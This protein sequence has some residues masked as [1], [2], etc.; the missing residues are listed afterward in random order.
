MRRRFAAVLAVLLL[1]G[2]L[3][4]PARAQTGE[5]LP[6][7]V[8]HIVQRGETL[9]SI[10]RRYGVTVDA[11]THA[12]GVS[13]PRRIYVGQRLVIPRGDPIAGE[14]ETIAYV[15][16][17]GD[18]LA[19][20]AR[21]YNTTWQ[22]LVEIND[23]LSPNV[24]YVGQVIQVPSSDVSV[25]E[26]AMQSSGGVSYVVRP[27]DTLVGIALRHG[28]SM[29]LLAAS[30]HVANP[31]LIYP[32]QELVIPGEGPGLLPDPFAYVE[33]MPLPVTQG[34]A[35]V[36]AVHAIGPVTL[37]GRMFEREV[38]FAEEGG[39]HYAV[40]GVDAL[41]E[42]GLYELGLIATD[43]EGHNA[44]ITTGV[45]VEEGAF[46]YERISVRGSRT[47]LLDPAVVAAERERLRS[48]VQTFSAERLW[49]GPFQRPGAGTISSFFG[50]H[51][52]YNGG[53]YTAYH[54]GVDLRA[55]TG[56]P[57]YACA[58]GTVVMAELTAIYG[59]LIV[60]DHGWGVLSGYG[61]LSTMEVAAGQQVAAGDLIGKVGNTGLS[62]GSHLHWEVWVGGISVNSLQ[63]LDESYPWSELEG[64]AA[65]G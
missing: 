13:D 46:G 3:A 36:V 22:T 54:S 39:V 28:V 18:T 40:V 21:R 35:V 63:W 31:A 14:R 5:P 60:V 43:A 32:G 55:P 29:W 53:P 45:V 24:A 10:T 4:L 17:A 25:E 59:N 49:T 47:S 38:H 6:E 57:V 12:N 2:G 27:G 42:P 61:H 48:S 16:Q 33:L 64:L 34:G 52:S 9:L 51:R 65:G 1:A 44:M 19:A 15:V 8:V 37:E 26:G 41:R 7:T 30:S 56:T 23:L 50:T 58:V 20:I 11:V 62:T